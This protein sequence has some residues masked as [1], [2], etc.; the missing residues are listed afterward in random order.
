M[1]YG[2]PYGKWTAGRK[3]ELFS[4]PE[5]RTPFGP[6]EV[7]E[8]VEM[9]EW[10]NLDPDGL[11]KTDLHVHLEGT[12]EPEMF[13]RFAARNRLDLPWKSP[14]EL[15]AA[16]HFRDLGGFLKIYFKAC[17]VL[18]TGRDFY[19]LTRA[20]LERAAEDGVVH[21]EMFLGP[22]TFLDAGVPLEAMMEGVFSAMEEM[23]ERISSL[24]LGSVIRSRPEEEAL[25]LL[26]RLTP[27][28]DRITGFGMG[29]AERGNPP[30]RFARYF[31]AVRE[32]GFRTTVHAGEEGPPEYVREAVELLH[33][34]RI[35]HGNA[36]AEDPELLRLLADRKIPLTLCPVSNL[37]LH[38]VPS[39]QDHPLKRMLRAGVRVTINSDDPAY[40][41]AGASGNWRA[42]AEA[43]HLSPEEGWLLAE[44]GI[45][46]S[47]LPEERKTDLFRRLAEFRKMSSCTRKD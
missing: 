25:A 3:R 2:T 34:D 42:V 47:F 31:S 46:A 19:E 38:V 9:S 29:G 1:W 39:L 18:R 12:M 8:A 23:K 21:T 41:L 14:E 40:F 28:Y 33:V 15:R 20:Y 7:P 43:L 36:A 32:R 11:P 24:F 6:D 44:N 17:E 5:K 45:A 10:K 37:R 26:D 30:G 4:L 35:D 13:F 22:Q 16:C 27:W